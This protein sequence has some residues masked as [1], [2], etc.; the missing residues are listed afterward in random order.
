VEMTNT[1]WRKIS[2]ECAPSHNYLAL[3]VVKEACQQES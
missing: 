2:I 3:Q 1:Y